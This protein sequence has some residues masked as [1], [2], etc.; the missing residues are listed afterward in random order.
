MQLVLEFHRSE[1]AD[2]PFAFRTGPQPYVRRTAGG[3]AETAMFDWDAVLLKDLDSVRRPGCDPA[4]VQRLG[5][6]LQ[7][8][9]A[10]TAWPRDAAELAAAVERGDPVS[11]TM[12]LSAAELYALP[13]ELL[14]L[15]ASGEHLGALP[16]VLFRYEWP[17]TATTPEK[18]SP[19]PEGG[20][21]LLAWSAACGGVPA[22]EHLEAISKACAQG[23]HSFDPSRDV[24]A[25]VSVEGLRQKL[26][27]AADDPSFSVLHILCH[28][29]KRGATFGLAWD[30][31]DEG[32]VDVVDGGRLQRVLAPYATRLRLVVLCVCD[33][34]NAAELGNH[35]GSV[36]QVLHRGGI[37]AVV[38]SRFPLSV[39]G[40][41]RLTEALYGRLLGQPASLE[42]SLSAARQKLLRLAGLDWA[43]VQLYL[44]SADGE[45]TRPVV[46]RPYRGLLAFEPQHHRFFFGRDDEDKEIRGD[47]SAL[48]AAGKPRLL[49]VAGA[50]GTGKSSLVLACAVPRL[51]QE[52]GAHWQLVR[53]RPGSDPQRA[54]EQALDTARKADADAKK[55]LLLIVDHFEELFTHGA[56]LPVRQAFAKQLW[57]LANDPGSGTSVLL[58]LRVDFIG[59]CGELTLDDSGLGLDRVAY[60]EAHRVFVARLGTEQLRAAIEEPARKVG[61]HLEQGLVNRMLQD[62]GT[63]PGALPL[64]EYTL[65]LLWEQRQ[66]PTLTQAAYDAVGGVTGALHGRADKLIDGLNGA[67]QRVARRLLVRLVSLGE[68]VALGTRQRVPLSKLRPSAPADAACFDRALALLIDARLLV[69]D[70]EKGQPVMIEVAHEALIRKWSRLAEWV[71]ADRPMLAELE[72]VES[73]VAQWKELGTLLSGNQLGHAA[74]LEKRY[75]ED[76]PADAHALL[77]ASQARADEEQRRLQRARRRTQL[78]AALFAVAAVVLGGLGRWAWQQKQQGQQRL[79]QLYE[80]QGL[81][82]LQ[83]GE[84]LRALVYL[85]KAYSE[86]KTPGVALLTGL[87]Q[88]AKAADAQLVSLEGHR[89]MVNSAAFSADG[90]RVVTAS[91]DKTAKVWDAHS[92]K[93]LLTLQGHQLEVQSAAFSADGTRV[94]TA[95]S[96]QTAKVWDAHS[97]KELLTLKGHQERVN[98]AAFSADGTRVVTASWDKTAKVWDLA[99][100]DRP[101][102]Q[103]AALVRCRAIF[104]LDEEGRLQPAIP[105]IQDCPVGKRA[106]LPFR[107]LVRVQNLRASAW[108]AIQA[109]NL[110]LAKIYGQQALELSQEQAWQDEEADTRLLLGQVARLNEDFREAQSNLEKACALYSAIRRPGDEAYTLDR[111]GVLKFENLHD[112]AAALADLDRARIL[113]PDDPLFLANHAEAEFAAG[114]LDSFLLDLPAAM[115]AQENPAVRVAL[116]AYAWASVRLASH[117][118]LQQRAQD[119]RQEYQSWPEVGQTQWS[120]AGVRYTLHELQRP[121]PELDQ[122][123]AV[124]DLLER[125]RSAET[126]K[127]LARLL[128]PALRPR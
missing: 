88:A 91:D 45:Q 128:Q 69:R 71:R 55:P 78:V 73:W 105:Q 44:R 51:L 54:L 7:R 42:S 89:G 114:K 113:R 23:Y 117:G 62:V 24:L 125:P 104:H 39:V 3:G 2:D 85:S 64:L 56:E 84:E 53:M 110:N 33:S 19:R 50:S 102:G 22:A 40:S 10:Q 98:S 32:E 77:A 17:E 16:G 31:S 34:A 75:R 103:I 70:A 82:E 43:G 8:F 25:Q 37:Q 119:F 109:S 57:A 63:E 97:G 52:K 96:D 112:S 21:I 92:G 68:G 67:E 122:V 121:R 94:V 74:E 99:M 66:G 111:L 61:L 90:T 1:N 116:A 30:G 95:S 35:L 123:L 41:E 108:A 72:K 126:T 120:F 14:T 18:P 93:E 59:Q 115:K 36:A 83:R 60:D 5:D 20:R 9:L 127:E 79:I 101:R 58:T 29:A 46:F 49:V 38:A 100:E 26:E 12:R 86:T 48:I 124:I 81:Q 47:L 6:R 87:A 107:K 28:G 118:D 65:D 27:A 4:I 106:E 80:E 11:I 76:F 13:W 15:K